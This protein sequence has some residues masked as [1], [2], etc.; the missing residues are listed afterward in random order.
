MGEKLPVDLEEGDA[1]DILY[2][3]K[4][5]LVQNF[6]KMPPDLSEEIFVVFIFTE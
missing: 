3:G 2:S 5:L 1:N 4:F 6:A